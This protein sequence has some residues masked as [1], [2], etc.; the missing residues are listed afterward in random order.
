MNRYV[1]S[2]I[3]WSGRQWEDNDLSALEKRAAVSQQVHIHGDQ[4]GGEQ[5]CLADNSS[6]PGN[7][8]R[9]PSPFTPGPDR[10]QDEGQDEDIELI[11]AMDL[12][13]IVGCYVEESQI[14]P[15]RVHSFSSLNRITRLINA[16][17]FA[18]HSGKHSRQSHG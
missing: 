9:D 2:R 13:V 6:P 4:L 17:E 3:D 10:R 1:Y 8:A 12:I 14:S 15:A 5:S 18:T 7:Q 11:D 16:D